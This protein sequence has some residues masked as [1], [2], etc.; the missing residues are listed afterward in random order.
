MGRTFNSIEWIRRAGTWERVQELD[1]RLS[2][3]LNGFNVLCGLD[4]S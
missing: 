4:E 2:I 1:I 3:P